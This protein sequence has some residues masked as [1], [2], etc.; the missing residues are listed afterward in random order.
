MTLYQF[1]KMSLMSVGVGSEHDLILIDQY[2]VFEKSEIIPLSPIVRVHNKLLT[3]K[4]VI[5]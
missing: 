3:K 4:M 5:M 1:V 2:V